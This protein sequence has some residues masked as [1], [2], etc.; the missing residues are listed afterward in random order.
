M[1]SSPKHC[2]G[3]ELL[4]ENTVHG[5]QTNSELSW[6]KFKI[7][8]GGISPCNRSRTCE[9]TLHVSFL[10][11]IE[12]G[13]IVPGPKPQGLESRVHSQQAIKAFYF[14]RL[15]L[16]KEPGN[17]TSGEGE[18]QPKCKLTTTPNLSE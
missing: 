13:L 6:G 9:I 12:K 3:G 7:G 18:E 16:C 8:M 4:L 2:R 14:H 5:F 1:F 11:T 10:N 15:P 17:M